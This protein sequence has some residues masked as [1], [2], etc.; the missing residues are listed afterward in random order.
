[1]WCLCFGMV[2]ST[3]LEHVWPQ[4]AGE[5]SVPAIPLNALQGG[6]T[7]A[8]YSQTDSVTACHITC[9]ET[10]SAAAADH[11]RGVTEHA[12]RHSRKYNS[13]HLPTHVLVRNA[14]ALVTLMETCVFLGAAVSM[15]GPVYP[16]S[17][18]SMTVPGT[19]ST[20]CQK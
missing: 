2:S 14:C 13:V 8:S 10:L 11:M 3:L 19:P 7:M 17:L 20:Q 9:H 1:M 18:R 6:P 12:D 16:L 5:P 15:P 4:L